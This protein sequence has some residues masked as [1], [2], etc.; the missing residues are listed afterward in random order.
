[1]LAQLHL[2]ALMYITFVVDAS[3]NSAGTIYAY[4]LSGLYMDW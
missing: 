3:C 4:M 2:L 1:M